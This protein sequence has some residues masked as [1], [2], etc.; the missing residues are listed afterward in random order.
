MLEGILTSSTAQNNNTVGDGLG[1]VGG[2]P[3][4]TLIPTTNMY[5]GSSTLPSQHDIE[6]MIKQRSSD[7]GGSLNQSA[8]LQ[9][10]TEVDFRASAG[11]VD[12]NDRMVDSPKQR[13]YVPLLSKKLN[14]TGHGSSE[15][16]IATAGSGTT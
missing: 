11:E 7:D 8:L 2:P 16:V 14:K 6:M 4:S 5:P 13:K 10:Q 9:H 12:L 15:N 1:V 3:A